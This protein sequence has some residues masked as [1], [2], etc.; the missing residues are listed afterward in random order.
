MIKRQKFV[1]KISV[2]IIFIIIILYG[3]VISI[4]PASS[5][6]D[7]KEE[8]IWSGAFQLAWNEL[9]NKFNRKYRISG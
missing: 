1:I 7:N 8:N 4:K 5:L 2:L 6:G 3:I 9:K